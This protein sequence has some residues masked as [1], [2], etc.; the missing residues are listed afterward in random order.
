MNYQLG[1]SSLR[2]KK[3]T[4]FALVGNE[5]YLKEAFIQLATEVYSECSIYKLFPEDEKEALELLGSEDLFGEKLLILYSFNKM[6]MEAFESAIRDYDSS[7]VLVIGDKAKTKAR[8]ITK[9]LSLVSVVEYKKLREYGT[10]YL[11]WIRGRISGAGFTA[12]DSIDQLLFSR[13]GPNMSAL[14]H[15]LDKLFIYRSEEK[16][17]T[18][19]DVME[20]VS[21]TSVSTAFELFESLLQNNVSKA[22]TCFYSYAKNQDNFIEIVGFL[23]SY[24]EKV[25]RMLLLKEKNFAV[26]DIADIVSIPRFLVKTR[27]MPRAQAFGKNRIASKIDLIC[28]LNVQL[29]QFKG[30]KRVLMEKFIIGFAK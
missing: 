27:Y 18:T 24:F 19:E 1:E 30:E 4:K 29:R 26:D 17:I 21:V 3:A 10:D 12:E 6:K 20:M 5:V 22:L 8:A 11:L 13:V 2:F 15:E 16:E 28:D 14:A 7:L 23:G 25:F 9:I